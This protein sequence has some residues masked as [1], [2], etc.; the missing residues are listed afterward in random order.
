MNRITHSVVVFVVWSD[1]RASVERNS[2]L[3]WSCLT[4]LS[5]WSKNLVPLFQPIRSETKTNRDSLTRFPALRAN[6]MYLLRVLIG[7]LSFVIGY[8][9]YYGFGFTTVEFK[10]AS[11]VSL[12]LLLLFLGGGG[13]GGREGGRNFPISG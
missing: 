5:D 13:G 12:L 4:T 1:F 2:C 7:S 6:Y 8:S 9:D 10:K 3:L 11:V